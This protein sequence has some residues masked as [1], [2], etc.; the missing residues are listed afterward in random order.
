MS[1]KSDS[2]DGKRSA[3]P[4]ATAIYVYCIGSKAAVNQNSKDA[5][6]TI[7]E[8]E[9]LNFIVEGELVAVTSKVPIAVY[10]EKNLHEKLLD[11]AWTALRAMRHERVV[12]HYAREA[13]IVPL[14]FGT[15][16]LEQSGVHA[17]LRERAPVL[18]QLLRQ[19]EG[20]EEW[21]INVYFDQE[22][23]FKGITEISER[24]R[25]LAEQ[26]R[27]ASPGQSYLLEK[28]VNSLRRDEARSEIVRTVEKLERGF[29]RHASS[30]R[31]L[32]VLKGE[33][34]EWGDVAARFAVLVERSQYKKFHDSL[35]K[36]A[37]QNE[38]TGLRLEFTGPLPPYN[39]TDV[40]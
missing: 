18:Q 9:Q 30:L 7:E 15:I 39:F 29:K 13:G 10:D 31:R 35:E 37:Q 23:L 26:A 12:E 40:E 5:V 2:M 17:M 25:N 11:P 38:K 24:L 16:Y 36:L 21:G 20:K 1:G 6:P 8:N 3:T 33:T 22:Q 28:K 4:Q 27:Q 34:S 19:L 32:R 14:R